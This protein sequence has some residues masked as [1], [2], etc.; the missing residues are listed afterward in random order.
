[1]VHVILNNIGRQVCRRTEG[2]RE[3]N[4]TLMV[5]LQRDSTYHLQ[6]LPDPLMANLSHHEETVQIMFAG[7][8]AQ[9]QRE[10]FLCYHH[11]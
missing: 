11:Y 7:N 10:R 6:I 2:K 5:T 4:A 9:L 8:E 1:M 3:D